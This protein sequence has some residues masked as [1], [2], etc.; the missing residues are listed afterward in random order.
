MLQSCR[1]SLKNKNI[2]CLSGGTEKS[3]ACSTGLPWAIVM[4]VKLQSGA[5][6]V[7]F[8]YSILSFR[9]TVTCS[10]FSLVDS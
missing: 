4:E 1:T 5:T 9:N 3:T 7:P 2:L 10:F 8:V 6:V